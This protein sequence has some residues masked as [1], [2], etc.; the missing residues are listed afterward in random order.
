[1]SIEQ[2]LPLSE[3][4][5]E[6]ETLHSALEWSDIDIKDKAQVRLLLPCLARAVR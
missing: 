5:K 2:P 3:V 6:G 4:P 1:M